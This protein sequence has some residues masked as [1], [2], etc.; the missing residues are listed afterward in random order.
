M[1]GVRFR[2]AKIFPMGIVNQFFAR[3]RVFYLSCFDLAGN[4]VALLRSLTYPPLA[5]SAWPCAA[6]LFCIF[7]SFFFLVRVCFCIHIFACVCDLVPCLSLDLP[8]IG[9]FWTG[10]ALACCCG[11]LLFCGFGF[12]DGLGICF[13]CVAIEPTRT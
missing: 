2:D 6:S 13:C 1:T 12:V 8:S 10:M 3:E 5:T 11:L 4:L 7:R 9:S